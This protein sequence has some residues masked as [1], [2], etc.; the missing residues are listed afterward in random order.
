MP[1]VAGP[2]R[3]AGRPE[4]R[5]GLVLYG[6][7]SLAVYMSGVV[8]EFW[9]LVR[10]ARRAEPDSPYNEVLAAADVDAT[11]DIVS[12]T[13]AGGINGV[14]LG[15]ALATGGD[16]SVLRGFWIDRADMGDLLH[17]ATDPSPTSLLRSDYFEDQL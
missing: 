13:S 5:F 15:K 10:A 4:V 1:E 2:G 7:V 14:L 16:L 17:K 3:A 12:G 6:G 8:T 9:H 11:V